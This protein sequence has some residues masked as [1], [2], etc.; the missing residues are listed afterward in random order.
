MLA[1]MVPITVVFVLS[2]ISRMRRWAIWT[3]FLGRIF[4]GMIREHERNGDFTGA[5]YIL[6][7]VCAVVA[8]FSKPIAV[9]ALAFI[10]VGDTFA[11]I[12]G[13]RWGRHRIFERTTLEGSAACL[14]STIIVALV[15]PG[16][17][18]PVALVGAFVAAVVEALPWRID[19]NV[20]VPLISGLVM[21]FHS[22]LSGLI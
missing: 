19:D 21:T 12:V 6:I 7:T 18:L 1:V 10:M 17:A 11:A 22:H 13:R 8:M 5:S 16:L 14:L 4:D 15:A 9:T 2:D 3:R 20:S